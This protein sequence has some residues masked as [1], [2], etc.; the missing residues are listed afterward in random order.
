M[1]DAVE[2]PGQRGA[3]STLLRAEAGHTVPVYRQTAAAPLQDP[4]SKN[5]LS[6]CMAQLEP[7]SPT[8]SLWWNLLQPCTTGSGSCHSE[9]QLSSRFV[10]P[11][12]YWFWYCVEDEPSDMALSTAGSITEDAGAFTQQNLW[13]RIG[14]CLL[15]CVAAPAW[16]CTRSPHHCHVLGDPQGTQLW[17]SARNH[18]PV[19]SHR[20]ATTSCHQKLFWFWL[21]TKQ[22][23]RKW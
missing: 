19:P 7:L 20:K 4:S 22:P 17:N 2:A 16:C 6:I 13:H 3:R 23:Q 11:P 14:V 18:R 21:G 5:C 12:K 8:Q 10:E 9:R 15:P 1:N